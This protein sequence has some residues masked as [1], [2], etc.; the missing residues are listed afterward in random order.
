MFHLEKALTYAHHAV[1]LCSDC[2]HRPPPPFFSFTSPP[3]KTDLYLNGG[4]LKGVE[5]Q[6][7]HLGA[8][9]VTWR[10]LQNYVQILKNRHTRLDCLG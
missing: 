1:A 7:Q 6:W 4:A 2:P 8:D 3:P 9:V 5:Q 10:L